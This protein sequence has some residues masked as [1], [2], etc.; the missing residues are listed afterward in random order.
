MKDVI[1]WMITNG[2]NQVAC[3]LEI[4]LILLCIHGVFKEKFKFTIVNILIILLE[5]IVMALIHMGHI[6]Q[7][8]TVIIYILLFLYCVW[9]FKRR[10][11]E[12]V[13]LFVLSVVFI[14]LIEIV[15]SLVAL[16][17]ATLFD[18]NATLM[19]IV[20]LIGV[21]LAA[22]IIKFPDIRKGKFS[23][24]FNTEKWGTLIVISG[25]CLLVI[26]IDYR[27]R[28]EVDQMYYFLFL[29]ACAVTC[30]TTIK[31]Q[32]ARHELEKKRLEL[33]MQNN[34]EDLRTS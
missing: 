7:L 21:L 9:R 11:W 6:G 15:S 5:L 26:L 10:F 34:H 4:L 23:L 13:G 22:A 1:L 12:T 2:E 25:L 32:E 27:L 20:N 18:N 29:I 28:G 19:I 8:A 14:A 33:Q 30:V 16:P 3:F 24:S 17:V 31:A